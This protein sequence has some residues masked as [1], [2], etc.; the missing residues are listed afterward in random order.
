MPFFRFFHT[1]A[2]SS[3]SVESTGGVIKRAFRTLAFSAAGLFVVLPLALG[4]SSVILRMQHRADERRQAQIGLM[5]LDREVSLLHDM[6]YKC[7]SDPTILRSD[8]TRLDA[9]NQN[10]QSCLM[11]LPAVE[12]DAALSPV[13]RSLKRY[14]SAVQ[15]EFALYKA[16]RDRAARSVH[17]TGVSPAGDALADAIRAADVRN[18]TDAMQANRVAD[19]GTTGVVLAAALLVFIFVRRSEAARRRG[20]SLAMKQQ[21]LRRSEERFRAL[22]RNAS[23]VISILTPDGAVRYLSPTA[24]RLWNCHPDVLEGTAIA[25]LVH[26]DERARL[27]A[28][29]AQSLAAPGESLTSELRLCP[30]GS[31][32]RSGD[33]RT[34]ETVWTNLPTEPGVEGVLLTCR[35]VSERKAFEEQLSHQAFHDSLTRLPNRAL[36]MERLGH[37][38]ARSRR[39]G[40]VVAVL[41]L[42]LDNFKIVN[43]SLG[44]EAG[45]SLLL[46][47][48]ERLSACVRPGDTVARLGGD[49]FTIL[50]EDLDGEVQAGGLAERIAAALSVPLLVSGREVFTTAS[51]GIACESGATLGAGR[52]PDDLVRDADTAMYHAKT[53][54]KSRSV[55]FNAG[56]NA[57]AVNRLEL[58]MDLRRA[59]EK[60]EFRV[61]YQPIVALDTRRVCEVEALVRWEHPVRGLVPPGDFIPLAEET[62]LIVP[63]G[64]WVLRQACRQGRIWQEEQVSGQP[65]RVSVN[66]SARQLQQPDLVAQVAEILA[67]TGLAAS[68]LKLEITESVMMLDADQ[69]IPRLHALRTLGVHLA[70]DDFG[71]GY[72]SMAYLSSLPIDTLKIDRSFVSKMGRSEDDAA[73]VRAIVTLAK[74]LSLQITSEGIETPAQL[75]LL[76]DLGCDQGQGYHFARPLPAS[77]FA[78]LLARNGE[79]EPILLSMS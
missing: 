58:E 16:G 62:G 31:R 56:M 68:C 73:I 63:I 75:A 79:R 11:A 26:P 8:S 20:V 13:R 50:L 49:E 6:E 39:Q 65:L 14:Q 69:T 5:R 34:F 23:D 36:F 66:V 38:L 48:A 7:T 21:T 19:G 9:I 60:E 53:E 67:E 28:L 4:L 41:F 47:V 72:S 1:R 10:I 77:D 57:Q 17:D 15:N 33:W 27:D 76:C 29:L 46:T 52:T 25:D 3:E 22:V 18:G 55:V 71:T 2:E 40:S 51:L 12:D 78:A 54:G 45:D 61:F 30:A 42:D 32:L 44:H 43:D 70:V 64:L 35:D 59:L 24:E 37:A 74:T